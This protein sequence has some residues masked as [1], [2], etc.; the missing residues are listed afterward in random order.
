MRETRRE[1][2][3]VIAPVS[4]GLFGTSTLVFQGRPREMPVPPAPADPSATAAEPAMRR[5][6]PRI[7]PA[8][9]DKEFRDRMN[10]LYEMVAKLKREVD[11]TP[12]TEIFS[13][14]IY[15]E[16]GEIEKLAK[17]LK[18]QAKG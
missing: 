11:A 17:Q 2:L 18:S 14:K 9:R 8:E 16:T 15:K 6:I 3:E 12:T 1:F 10:Q 7:T 5:P 13:V 4:L